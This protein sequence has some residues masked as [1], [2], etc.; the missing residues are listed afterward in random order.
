MSLRNVLL[1]ITGDS[2]DAK[3]TIEEVKADVKSLDGVTGTAKV[4]V[5]GAAAARARIDELKVKLGELDRSKATPKVE[6]EIAAAEAQLKRLE[7]RLQ[8][9]TDI[10]DP[11]RKS[12][13]LAGLYSTL[14]S[15][16]D[17]VEGRAS[18]AAAEVEKLGHV[19]ETTAVDGEKA[20]TGVLGAVTA[21]AT[22]AATGLETAAEGAK[23]FLSGIPII[24]NALSGL[25]GGVASIASIGPAALLVVP[26][27]GLLVAALGGALVQA[28]IAA[29]AAVTAL[30]TVF[31]GAIAGAAAL[32][33]A[34]AA[35][36]APVAILAV[37]GLAK[38]AK[39]LLAS[40]NAANKAQTAHES[41]AQAQR[42]QAQASVGLADAQK[43]AS[44]QR[45][46]ALQDE[47]SAIEGVRDAE[48]ARE[49][50]VLGKTDA[51]L[52]LR[53]ARLD[54]STARGQAGGKAA[55]STSAPLFQK[56][57]NLAVDPAT[58]DAT[59]K[60]LKVTG[61][62]PSGKSEA[63]VALD[64]A[65]AVEAVRTA[66]LGVKQADNSALHAQDAY[67]AALQK[68]A[69]YAREGLTAFK[70]YAAALQQVAK[71]QSALATAEEHTAKARRANVTATANL[72]TATTG[73]GGA[74]SGFLK[75]VQATIG[76]A[77]NAIFAGAGKGMAAIGASLPGLQGGFT[78]LGR[79]I[80]DGLAT[81]GRLFGS[82]AFVSSFGA[83]TRTAADLVRHFATPAV[84]NFSRLLL[85]IAN[86][87]LPH[88]RNGLIE[89][90]RKFGVFTDGATKGG[91]VKRVVDDI[92]KSFVSVVNLS[93][94]V[95]K[96][97][98][99]IF[100]GGQTA[101]RHL[102][103]KLTDIINAFTAGLGT[104]EGK[105]KLKEFF[106]KGLKF[107][108]DFKV[109]ITDTLI[110]AVQGLVSAFD[111]V[112]GAVDTVK[113][114]IHA[115]KSVLDPVLKVVHEIKKT[116][117]S[118]SPVGI[119]ESLLKKIPIIGGPAASVLKHLPFGPGHAAGGL[120]DGPSHPVDSILTPLTGGEFIIQRRIVQALGVPF[121]QALNAGGGP[122]ALLSRSM[123]VPMPASMAAGGLG[124]RGLPSLASGSRGGASMHNEIHYNG[125]T[126][127]DLQHIHEVERRRQAS[128]LAAAVAGF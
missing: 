29:A 40:K 67:T 53:Q 64:L 124:S 3:A 91:H 101:G 26:V 122:G 112:K 77:L 75:V 43:N 27:V 76:P 104:P 84:A 47:K 50:A 4:E 39:G 72:K 126:T 16:L 99:A 113:G 86:A 42:A 125:F 89:L 120:V 102:L 81:L 7:G 100:A 41:L 36:A 57:T 25:S 9:A 56:L 30:V 1:K 49:S 11:G 51:R 18:K 62:G 44:E 88:L 118:I 70:P 59:L 115:V 108:H 63:Q 98:V 52:A 61:G 55:A 74:L 28:A 5:D 15:G 73:I 87:A 117:D 45:V 83:F 106:D 22:A 127:A 79:A 2:S 54:L 116:L 90:G 78:T 103:G 21:G 58:V 114:A 110:P 13:A 123:A 14:S 111:L 23:G 60:G 97:L 48:L 66:K 33:I 69:K 6:L 37:A 8:R 24:G 107:A 38:L 85:S 94:A 35:I 82:P 10:K 105:R 80:G 12:N 128:D 71:S 95:L 96:A 46:A 109:F 93:G 65:K 92:Y 119:G 32:G 20:A 68:Q 19:A 34:F 121:L 17:R 31:A